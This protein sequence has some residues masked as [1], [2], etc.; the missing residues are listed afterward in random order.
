[1]AT[2]EILESPSGLSVY[3]NDMRVAGA[4][5]VPIARSVGTWTVKDDVLADA[6]KFRGPQTQPKPT[7]E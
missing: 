7:K 2:V 5:P 1:M 3:V 6:I 4:K